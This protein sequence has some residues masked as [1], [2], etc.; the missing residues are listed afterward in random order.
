MSIRNR[1]GQPV[2][3]K[4]IIV[5]FEDDKYRVVGKADVNL[6]MKSVLL[7]PPEQEKYARHWT[8]VLGTPI[9]V[10]TVKHICIVHLTLQPQ[11]WDKSTSTWVP[12]EPY[13]VTDIAKLS[14]SNS[15]LFIQLMTAAYEVAGIGDNGKSG[16]IEEVALG[17]SPEP[18]P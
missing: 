15:L 8:R 18:Q 11:T 12:E 4:E 7:S 13:D 17:N 2:I 16:T 3:E 1:I 9:D 6:L 10:E 5:E 14:T